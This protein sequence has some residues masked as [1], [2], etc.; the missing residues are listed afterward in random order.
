MVFMQDLTSSDD[1]IIIGVTVG[2]I[3]FIAICVTAAAIIAYQ[4]SSKGKGEGKR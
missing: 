2:S 4:Y 1:L 3:S